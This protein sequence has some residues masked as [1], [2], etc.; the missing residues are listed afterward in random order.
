MAEGNLQRTPVPKPA[1]LEE[2]F[3]LGLRLTRGVSF[4]E[5]AEEFGAEAAEFA[6][7]IA[8]ELI[9]DGL[10]E[11]REDR[12]RLTPRGCLLSNEVFGRFMLADKVTG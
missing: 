12:I 9:E 3:F 4:V 1:A 11:A 7:A 2:S 10:L 6:R 5:I 8:T